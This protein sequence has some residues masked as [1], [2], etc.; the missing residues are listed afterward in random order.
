MS[1]KIN[2]TVQETRQVPEQCQS[3]QNVTLDET[4]RLL[5]QNIGRMKSTLGTN[6]SRAKILA[7]L[8]ECPCLVKCAHEIRSTNYS[9]NIDPLYLAKHEYAKTKLID[10]IE[11]RFA[12]LIT[13]SSE[14]IVPN[15]KLDISI[16]PAGSK[17]ILKY[18]KKV[19]AIELKSGKSADAGMLFQIERYLPDCDVLI[20]V[21]ILTEE[22]TLI[23]RRTIE[24]NLTESMSRLNRKI[25]RITNGELIKVQG[26]WCRGCTADCEYKKESRWTGDYKA[27]LDNFPIFIQNIE[28]VISKILEILEK[29]LN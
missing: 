5:T 12:D 13:V 8:H 6:A 14:H 26:D 11:D 29:E 4:N 17:I 20:F 25:S 2:K 1:E 15:G 3:E 22:V 10:A 19:I 7:N 24:N 18:N 21:R 9:N 23:E 28:R 16:I 27:S